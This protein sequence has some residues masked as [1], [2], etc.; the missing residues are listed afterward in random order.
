MLVARPLGSCERARQTADRI[1]Q[2]RVDATVLPDRRI[3]VGVN[4]AAEHDVGVAVG[5]DLCDFA[6][7]VRLS[8]RDAKRP[9]FGGGCRCQAC[10]IEFVLFVWEV[11]RREIHPF[12]E[13]HRDDV[14]DEFGHLTEVSQAVLDA[15]RAEGDIGWVAPHQVEV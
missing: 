15:S 4:D 13:V 12:E 1:E 14:G 8:L 5:H 7:E 2:F 10:P 11:A 3:D 6:F 9:Y